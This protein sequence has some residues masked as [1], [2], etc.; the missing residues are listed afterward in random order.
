MLTL[1]ISAKAKTIEEE[2]EKA[3]NAIRSMRYSEKRRSDFEMRKEVLTERLTCYEDLVSQKTKYSKQRFNQ[4]KKRIAQD[5]INQ[6]RLKKRKLGAGP[7]CLLDE[8][9]EQFIAKAIESKNT[10][11]G[12]RHNATL[13][14]H[15]RVKYHD[16]LSLANYSLAKRRK[17]LIRSASTVYLRARFKRL[18]TIEGRRHMESWLF[19]TK[20]PPT[21]E[22]HY[23]ETTHHHWAHVKLNRMDMFHE[24]LSF[25]DKAYLRPGTDCG[26]RETKA[27]KIIQVSDEKIQRK[28]PQHDFP[29][30]KICITPRSFRI[31]RWKTEVTDGKTEQIQ[32]DDQSLVTILP[33]FYIGSSGSIWASEL[34]RIYYEQPHLFEIQGEASGFSDNSKSV[35]LQIRD[36]VVYFLAST[37]ETDL[38][39][40][41]SGQ[42]DCLSYKLKRISS[43]KGR[44]RKA[45][46]QWMSEKEKEKPV[47]ILL[48]DSVLDMC[49][50]LTNEFIE[51]ELMFY[52]KESLMNDT[53]AKYVRV[54]ALCH[55]ILNKIAAYEL[56]IFCP[57]VSELTDAGP[58]VGVTNFEVT[59]RFAEICRL[60]GNDRRTRIHRARGDSGQNEAERTNGSTGD[61]LVDGSIITW[62]YFLP[63]NGLSEEGRKTM[64]LDELEKHKETNMERNAWAVAEEVRMRADDEKGPGGDFMKAYSTEKLA[65]QFF[66]NKDELLL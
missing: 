5:L 14:L 3:E 22:G 56:P 8:E 2:L 65:D 20:R 23:T 29:A 24:E 46:E 30:S 64:S 38:S 21:T 17:R 49:Q 26:F 15:H 13:Y 27:S 44:L 12:R 63:Y 55:H 9:D 66:H 32:S 7:P 52:S 43:I 57:I 47:R 16:L 31:M 42:S 45:E 61:A 39:D 19:C 50:N 41:R 18:N 33:K 10:A 54:K 58:G 48:V 36:S 6:N 62:D 53:P 25:D 51:L 34:L 40:V 4:A 37:N 1:R 28:L 60:H 59:F 35:M 11:H